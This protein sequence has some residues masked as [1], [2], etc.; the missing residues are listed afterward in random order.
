[1]AT[2]GGIAFDIKRVNYSQEPHKT[3]QTL[4]KRVTKNQIIGADSMDYLLDI[5]GEI[6]ASTK[7]AL[8]TLRNNLEALHDGVKHAFAD[9]SETRYDGDYVIDTGT[10]TF[11]RQ[12]GDTHYKFSMRLLEW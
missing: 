12:E 10:L 4:G 1:M 7:T 8:Q 5:N 11:E 3:K 6:S 9:T 2:Y